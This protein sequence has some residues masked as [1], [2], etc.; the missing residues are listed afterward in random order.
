MNFP[1]GATKE[2]VLEVL[3]QIRAGVESGDSLEG[4]VQWSIPYPPEGEPED[5][6]F[7]LLARYRIGNLMGQGGLRSYGKMDP[8]GHDRGVPVPVDS[9]FL[10]YAFR[11]A[12]G[13]Q[14]YAVADVANTLLDYRGHLREDWRV[15]IVRDIDEAIAEG[16]AGADF[17]VKRWAEVADAFRE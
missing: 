17:D 12:L 10:M 6:D 8:P 5:A 14:S 16:R 15:Q 9:V 13:R 1:E 7:M 2:L 3:D 4:F 11:Y